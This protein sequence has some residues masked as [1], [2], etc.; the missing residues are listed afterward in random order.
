MK[1]VLS[2]YSL[3]KKANTLCRIYKFKVYKI[4]EGIFSKHYYLLDYSRKTFRYLYLTPYNIK[5]FDFFLGTISHVK[6]FSPQSAYVTLKGI[7]NFVTLFP[8]WKSK[9]LMQNLQTFW[10]SLVTISHVVWYPTSLCHTQG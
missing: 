8:E 4:D 1:K 3:S 9:F 5:H 6:P 7:K 10:A 2:H